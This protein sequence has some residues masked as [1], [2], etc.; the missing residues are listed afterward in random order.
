MCAAK[1]VP[2]MA[3]SASESSAK[4]LAGSQHARRASS[5]P[6]TVGSTDRV[7]RSA[8]ATTVTAQASALPRGSATHRG[9]PSDHE[10]AGTMRPVSS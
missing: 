9:S 5:E 8:W 4:V 7:P 1:T 6:T 10:V 2:P 3:F